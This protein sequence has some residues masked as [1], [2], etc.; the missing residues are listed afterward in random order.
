MLTI[1]DIKVG[2]RFLY[3]G[4][5]SM[6]QEAA[7]VEFTPDRK[8]VKLQYPSGFC[9]WLNEQETKDIFIFCFL[10]KL[11]CDT[12]KPNAQDQPPGGP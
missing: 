12:Q 11:T 4:F 1:D 5:A 7:C 6:V 8:M 2:D 10:P 9:M 3:R